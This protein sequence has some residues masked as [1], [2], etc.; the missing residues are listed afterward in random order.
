MKKK[1]TSILIFLTLLLIININKIKL[2]GNSLSLDAKGAIL[3]EMSTK[4]VLYEKDAHSRYLTASIA[5]IMTA[6]V[7]IE[8]GRL[9]DYYKVDYETTLQIGSSI[10]LQKD[11]H[12]RLIDLVYGLML[13]SGNDA[14]HMIALCVAG[15]IDGFAR[16]M[17]DYAKK[18]GMTNSTFE[19]PSGLD[20]D[21]KNYSTAYD[22]ALLTSYAMQ[23]KLF[24]KI[25]GTKQ[26]V[27][28]TLEGRKLY[29]NNTHRMVGKEKYITGGKPGYTEKA[30]RTLVTTAKK[31][32]ME[33]VVVTFVCGN[34]W[35][36]HR[37]LFNYGF[38]N[39][40]LYVLFK[41][42]T[43]YF[44]TT[45][46]TYQGVIPKNIA[47][48]VTKDEIGRLSCIVHLYK[49]PKSNIVGYATIYLDNKELSKIDVLRAK[50]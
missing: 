44:K 19:N 37:N 14:A 12:I 50:K 15:S 48:P 33:L 47:Y 17:N 13:R 36:A 2:S 16:M 8:N 6:I 34:D 1:F 10:Y 11:E 18:I 20:D 26:Y 3:M 21:S 25:A 28:T 5:K 9:E 49:N 27:A 24:R 23:N 39:Y 29:F 30:F 43:I 32:K 38:D 31:D 41:K 4:R 22:M 42:Q 45:K 35:Q 46:Q 40:F 7:A